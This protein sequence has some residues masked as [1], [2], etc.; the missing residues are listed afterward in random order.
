MTFSDPEP[1]TDPLL[2]E[3]RRAK[4]AKDKVTY[5]AACEAWLAR[6]R[7]IHV[8]DTVKLHYSNEEREIVVEKFEL[9]WPTGQDIETPTLVFEGPTLHKCPRRVERSSNWCSRTTS[10]SK[11]SA[12][13]AYLLGKLRNLA[14]GLS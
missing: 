12:P 9:H 8:G 3:A 4:R 10:V 6:D 7:G 5:K 11:K 14:V 2:E 1:S 13:S